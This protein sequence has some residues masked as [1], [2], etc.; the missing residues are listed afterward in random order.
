[1][2][3]LN[4]NY[5][6]N[7]SWS[8]DNF[9]GNDREEY[10]NLIRTKLLNY[11]IETQSNIMKILS[12]SFSLSKSIT[13]NISNTNVTLDNLSKL[14]SNTLFNSQ[15]FL[16]NTIGNIGGDPLT[17]LMQY[18]SAFFS[19]TS[20]HARI[21]QTHPDVIN[22]MQNSFNNYTKAMDLLLD[23]FNT[24]L[25]I[26]NKSI[27]ILFIVCSIILFIVMAIFYFLIIVSLI[28]AVKSRINYMEVFNGINS[29]TLKNL[30]FD[31]ENLMNRLKKTQCII[32]EGESDE[33]SENKRN[34]IPNNNKNDNAS[35]NL[36]NNNIGYKKN[37][38]TM[39]KNIKLFIIFFLI[40]LIGE[41]TYYPFNFYQ[42]YNLS[43]QSFAI[44]EFFYSVIDFHSTVLNL[45]NAYRE[46]LL[47]NRTI[48]N[49]MDVFDYLVNLEHISYNT[50]PDHVNYLNYYVLN[51]IKMNDEMIELV[52]K[53]LCSYYLTDI[54]NNKEEC[55]N[56]YSYI[57]KYD[58]NT[59]AINFLQNIRYLKNI[60]KYRLETEN[61]V[62]DLGM[63]E[64]NIQETINE[65]EI[66]GKNYSFRLD[67]FNNEILHSDINKIFINILLPYFDQARMAL[68][69]NV[70]I[71][72][73]DYQYIVYICLFLIIITFL[74]FAYLFPMIR[75]LNN[76]IYR[77]K[78]ILLIIPTKI[79][80]SQTNIKT[81]LKLT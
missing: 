32:D 17:T 45:F 71:D 64:H 33:E 3:L 62:G 15:L 19:L 14:L 4:Y 80:A 6:L 43:N 46:Y 53:D 25:I 22:F 55:F 74:Y 40:I 16:S 30:I 47:D 49:E 56:N 65:L 50:I 13:K 34:I 76:S 58:F 27:L 7:T 5:G 63:D 73:K 26:E 23:K 51:N 37:N 44:Y 11:C 9:P 79:L 10:R 41:Y 12:T 78:K 75:H 52:S 54:F 21:T 66:S 59:F 70:S 68:F 24:E 48:I 36:L 20:D 67:L 28:S 60:A 61:L 77:T 2:T 31:C 18:N 72:G 38:P 69:N 35:R 57:L 1:M 39:S 29:N 42:L 81:L 8:Y